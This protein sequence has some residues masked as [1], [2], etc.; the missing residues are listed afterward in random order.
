MF[1]EIFKNFSIGEAQIAL[2]RV[3]PQRE[4]GDGHLGR[5]VTAPR[6]L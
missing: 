3:I 1:L 6:L 5:T 2:I 4:T